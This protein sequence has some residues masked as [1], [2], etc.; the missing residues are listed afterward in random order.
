MVRY[1]H[2]F[3]LLLSITF[4]MHMF[5]L[6]RYAHTLTA[7]NAFYGDEKETKQMEKITPNAILT[8]NNNTPSILHFLTAGGSTPR[9]IMFEEC[10]NFY[11]LSFSLF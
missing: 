4:Y 5:V 7:S 10:N 8:L 2:F 9:A 6:S 11:F 3:W 1:I